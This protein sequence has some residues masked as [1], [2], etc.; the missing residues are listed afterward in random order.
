MRMIVCISMDILLVVSRFQSLCVTLAVCITRAHT[1][2][3]SHTGQSNRN[4]KK[5]QQQNQNEIHFL[6]LFF[7][8]L[9]WFVIVVLI[10]YYLPS[11][12]VRCKARGVLKWR[13]EP[14]A[15][16][17]ITIDTAKKKENHLKRLWDATSDHR[18]KTKT[19]IRLRSFVV[20][21]VVVCCYFFRCK[22]DEIK[23]NLNEIKH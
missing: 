22:R 15:Q 21:V 11:A 13:D 20:A 7:S 9:S 14:S 10:H 19:P 17:W 12:V 2:N 18:T 3:N 8:P 6:H 1:L 23:N 5:Q 16:W 4:Q